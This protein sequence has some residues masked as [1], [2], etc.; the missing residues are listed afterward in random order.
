MI[1]LC[2]GAMASGKPR[3]SCDGDGVAFAH[4]KQQW[5]AIVN[6][7]YRAQRV[8]RGSVPGIIKGGVAGG[9]IEGGVVGGVIGLA[10]VRRRAS[11]R[12]HPIGR[13]TPDRE[14]STR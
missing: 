7:G 9:V 4:Y 3:R 6:Q 10:C 14:R 12:M 13:M 5:V 11:N 1:F 2:E 8:G